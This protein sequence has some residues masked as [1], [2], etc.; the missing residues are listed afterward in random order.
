M[1]RRHKN[2]LIC[3]DHMYTVRIPEKLIPVVYSNVQDFFRILFEFGWIHSFR[4][5]G[6]VVGT[7]TPPRM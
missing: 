6:H 7:K 5:V 1:S 4:F 3:F 2:D